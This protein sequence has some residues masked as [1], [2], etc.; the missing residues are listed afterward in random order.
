M[1]HVAIACAGSC[2]FLAACSTPQPVLNQANHTAGLISEYEGAL[3]EFDRVQTA[4]ANARLRSIA[5]QERDIAA[6]VRNQDIA[7]TVRAVVGDDGHTDTAAKLNTLADMIGNADAKLKTSGAAT[8]TELATL[9]KPLPSTAEKAA[10]AQKAVAQMGAELSA[11]ERF[12]EAKA[13]YKVVKAGADENLK[14]IKDA[15]AAAAGN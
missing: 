12:S 14:K 11:A 2:L 1:K 6:T 8:G 4:A 15:Q 9:L 10:A 3:E 5:V 7:A 13:F